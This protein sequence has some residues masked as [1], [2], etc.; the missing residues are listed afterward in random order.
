MSIVQVR[1]PL[2]LTGALF[3]A[4]GRREGSAGVVHGVDAATGAAM[5]PGFGLATRAD[6]AD[7][8]A[9]AA[10]AAPVLRAAPRAVRSALLR[11]IAHGL[12]A[13]SEEL[14][15]R[16]GLETGLPQGRLVGEVSRTSGQ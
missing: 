14:V 16:A 11:G 4:G 13:R 1:E 15:A 3:V 2:A 6:A 12:D 8:A 10:E 9:A 7:A 5:E